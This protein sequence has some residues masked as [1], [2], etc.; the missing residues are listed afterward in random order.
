MKAKGVLDYIGNTPLIQLKDIG[1]GSIFAKAE[2]LNPAGSIKDRVANY[3]IEE[4]ERK[5]ELKP[6]SI[7]AEPS[8]GNT[9]IG[10]VFVGVQK[11]YRVIIAMPEDM[12][13]E[14]KK[15]IR[16]MGGELILT[17]AEKSLEG[18]IAKV[19]EIAANDS[20]VYIPHQFENPRN[21]EIHYLTTGQEIW[22]QIEGR[23]DFFI[24]GVGSGGTLGGVGKLMKENV[25]LKKSSN[26]ST[27]KQI[28]I[29]IYNLSEGYIGE[30]V[31][32]VIAAS[33]YAIETGSEK[34]TLKELTNCGFVKPSDRKKFEDLIEL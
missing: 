5:G 14:R 30:I 6:D 32:L 26:I 7:I 12:S 16:A 17:P 21:P 2:H 13:E 34:I 28:A 31:D 18:S 15:I 24:A 27:N 8:S 3:M 11:G 23:I 33:I 10:L 29:K 25:V 22:D 9:G 4:A 19:E 20:R 1:G